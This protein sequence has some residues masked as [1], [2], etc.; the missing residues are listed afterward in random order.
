MKYCEAIFRTVRR[1]T[2]E[3]MVGNV[4]V[5]GDNP[6]RIQSMTTS[7]T[8]D[9]SSTIDQILKLSDSGCEIARVT[10]QG[11]KEAEACEA[12]KNGL[13]QKGCTIPL[14]A[15]IHF[16]PPAAMLVA[17]FVD[18]I[19]IN[20]G[21]YVDRRAI[22]KTIDYTD[23]TYAL[24]MQKIEEGF[25]PLVEKCR[26][27]RRAM[28]IGTNHGSLS[29][30]IMSRYGD[31]PQGMVESALEFAKVCRKYDYHDF[32]F[33]M[34]A[35]NPL[36]MLQA[37]RLLALQM[38]KLGWDYPLHLGVTEAGDGED[39]RIKSAVGIGALLLDGLGDTVRVSLTEDPWREIDPCRRLI[40]VA[41]AYAEDAGI[42]PFQENHRHIKEIHR[43]PLIFPSK[44]LHSQGSVFLSVTEKDV[45]AEDFF[46]VIGCRQKGHSVIEKIHSTI[47]GIIL[48]NPILHPIAHRKITQLLQ[49]GMTV[50][51][52]R[53]IVAGELALID[54]DYGFSLEDL[55]H[56]SYVLRI[57][58]GN[59]ENWENAA[60]YSPEF[61][62]F[63]MTSRKFFQGRLFLEWLGRKNIKIPVIL[64]AQY[65]TAEW[66]NAVIQSAAEIG[67]LLADGLGEGV[68]IEGKASIIT[69]KNLSFSI[70][71]AARLRSSKT[72]YIAC[73]GCGR[74]L[75]DLQSVTQRI[76][77]KTSH[78]AGVKIAIM[79][80][81]VNGPGE[82]ADADFGYVGSKS[83]KVDLYVG[84]KCVER[85]I[86]QAVADERLI[87]LI[88]EYGKWVEP[89]E[90]KN[91]VSLE[92]NISK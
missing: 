87:N 22:F 42:P 65:N 77:S 60:L 58:D 12:I 21:N 19:R 63:R 10:V 73:P 7:N 88:K 20:P 49:A 61:I 29:D 36:I 44:G 55:P 86:D 69:L 37:Y 85:N 52:S 45:M 26:K 66:E 72:E 92:N 81:I 1:K 54:Y 35:S 80:C 53:P 5:G 50:I 39:G 57:T 30:R 46:E 48:E 24:E 2:R 68:C 18:K 74:T 82:M 14:V 38:Y 67:S 8:R 84:K 3:V 47:D 43:R 16:Y 25:A 34:K 75:F 40:Q 62:I 23:D 27:L 56:A 9:I 76:R 31:T 41:Q 15:D 78:L 17:E 89:D 83:G 51:S 32:I 13:L 90:D 11:K 6:I 33:S 4:G 59:L 28:R 64:Q 79:G 70:L 91:L 71:Q